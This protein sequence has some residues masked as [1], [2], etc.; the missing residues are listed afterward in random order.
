MEKIL[1]KLL[2][3]LTILE[4]EDLLTHEETISKN[5]LLLKEAMLNI[6]QLVDPLIVDSKTKLVLD[7]N[8]RKKVLE[9]IKC[10]RAACQMVDYGRPDIEV[11]T[12]CPVS[13]VVKYDALKKAGVVVEQVDF[14]AGMKAV[15]SNK[16]P[17]LFANKKASSYCLVNPGTY[18]LD[19]LIEEQRKIISAL[20]EEKFV[21]ISDNTAHTHLDANLSVLFR[22]PFT[23][24]EIIRR[25]KSNVPFPPKSTR[26]VIPNRIIRLNM[27][28]GWLHE[29][30]SSAH[31]YLKRMLH[32]RVYENSVRY[33]P[34]SV[35]VIY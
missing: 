31:A 33:Y 8:H 5:L 10:P 9:L 24:E 6:G 15:S 1:E 19:E 26:H 11:G 16:A 18:S 12:W 3:E 35:I 13:E 7:G 29:S 17:Y 25:A 28:L 27:R 4:I 20:G 22:R 21:Y 32:D 23:K 2:R 14:E 30:G 34:E